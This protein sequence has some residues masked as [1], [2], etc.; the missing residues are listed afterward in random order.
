MASR[1]P[2]PGKIAL[3]T[4]AAR[5]I[6]LE[7]A[8][9]LHEKGAS[10]AVVDLSLEDARRACEAIGSRTLA[11]EADVTDAGA[12]R[13]AV[14]DVVE[15]FGGVDIAVANAGVAP[16]MKPMTA[17]GDEVFERVVE[18][19]LLGVWRT[20]SAVL[21]QIVARGG[22]VVVVASVA[23][24]APGALSAPY[25]A[26]K[27]GVEQLGRALRAELRTHSASASVA[28]F[29][30]IDTAMVRDTFDASDDPVAARVQGLF[31]GFA[32]RR[33]TPAQA[34]AAV[35]AG[36]ERRAAR[37]ITPGYWRVYSVLRGALN[38]IIDR[39]MERD[40]RLLKAVRE[41]ETDGATLPR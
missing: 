23:A 15:R 24:F 5:G 6:G 29:G 41:A 17:I 25:A 13:R 19:D 38:P 4:G 9:Q 28:Y 11:L 33:Q 16:P 40:R 21:P 12:L 36:I 14:A 30:F 32:R 3:V 18:V 1:Y 31:P 7:T 39:A 27:A 8:K 34:G 10:V 37:I 20:V 26:S 35:V 2:L 22:H